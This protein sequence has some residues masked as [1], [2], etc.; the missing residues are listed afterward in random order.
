MLA[1]NPNNIGRSFQSSFFLPA[2]WGSWQPSMTIIQQPEITLGTRLLYAQERPLPFHGYFTS[3]LS[4]PPM[5]GKWSDWRVLIQILLFRKLNANNS[6]G[7][8]KS[9]QVNENNRRSQS[10]GCRQPLYGIPKAPRRTRLRLLKWKG[11]ASYPSEWQMSGW[12]FSLLQTQNTADC[13]KPGHR[14]NNRETERTEPMTSGR[15]AR[16]PNKKAPK[17]TVANIDQ[18]RTIQKK[19]KRRLKRENLS[20]W[21]LDLAPWF[22]KL[23]NSQHI[24]L[25]VKLEAKTK[26]TWPIGSGTLDIAVDLDLDLG[27][28][29]PL[30]RGTPPLSTWSP[31]D[32]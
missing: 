20:N 27:K 29:R 31:H 32:P 26:K 3:L 9:R 8:S 2:I 17:R 10:E 16:E 15:T 7:F 4:H 14:N 30:A 12:A 28:M 24:R 6:R 1:N 22:W 25:G 21:K 23:V 19:K 18:Y 11:L 13:R 5:A